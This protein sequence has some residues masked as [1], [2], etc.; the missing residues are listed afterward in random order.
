MSEAVTA[1]AAGADGVGKKKSV[2]VVGFD[3]SEQSIYALKWVL[4]H[5]FSDVYG[6]PSVAP[7][8]LVVVHSKPSPSSVINLA[9]PGTPFLC[10][11]LPGWRYLISKIQELERM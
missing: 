9:S 6:G 1:A 11:F 8:K 4:T 10:L 3:D 5:F 7:F 2:V